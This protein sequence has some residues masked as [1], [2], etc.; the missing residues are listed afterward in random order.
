MS[1][2]VCRSC[3]NFWSRLKASGLKARCPT[4]LTVLTRANSC[5]FCQVYAMRILQDHHGLSEAD[6][7]TLIKSLNREISKE[8]AMLL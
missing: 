5:S 8:D 4:F 7:L 3:R 2:L 6:A 1:E